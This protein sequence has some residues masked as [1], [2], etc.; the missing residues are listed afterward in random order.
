MRLNLDHS[1]K[2]SRTKRGQK[3]RPDTVNSIVIHTTGYGA[4]LSRLVKKY[5]APQKANSY[6]K[7]GEQ[8]A[9]RMANILKYKGHILIDWTGK[10]HQFIDFDE[11][12]WHTGSGKRWKL[13]SY[14]PALWY[15]KKW[16]GIIE[17]P[18]DLPS[19][20][21][22]PGGRISVNARS[23]G[24]D[25]LAHGPILDG[26]TDAQYESLHAVVEDVCGQLSIPFDIKHVVGH[27]DVHPI[28]RNGW[29]PGKKFRWDRLFPKEQNS[30]S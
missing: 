7:V 11:E 29:D 23:I 20:E 1:Y 3:R 6:E 19:W 16:G 27:E 13:K 14:K 17:N 30:C 10:V 2:P 28:D 4:G 5:G 21:P 25:L 15:S 12:A 24:I 18:M 8:Y 9:K 22:L 26:Y